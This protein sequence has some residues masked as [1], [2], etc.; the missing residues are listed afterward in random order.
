MKKRFFIVLVLG[1]L[2]I[3]A[4]LA[5][6]LTLADGGQAKAA[7]VVAADAS[8]PQRHAA[9][10]LAA[11]LK[12]VTGAQFDVVHQRDADK[13]NLLVGAPAAKLVDPGFSIDG[14]GSDGIVIRTVGKDLIL[15]G[16]EPRGTLYAVYTFLEEQAGC[17][18]WSSTA[19]T[20]P[21]KPVL[22]VPELQ[23]R[24]VPALEH[25]EVFM[26]DSIDPDWSV[27]NKCVGETHGMGNLPA[28]AQ[29]GGC[30]KY[31]PTAHSF[32]IVLPPDR[33]FKDH[34]E[35]YSLINGKRTAADSTHSE[36]CLTN[37]QMRQE[38]TRR[39]K[40]EVRWASKDY[41]ARGVSVSYASIGE[42]DDAGYPCRCQCDKCR[43]VEIEEGSPAGLLLRFTNSVAAE[44]E[45]EFP[46]IAISMLAYHSWQKPPK[47]TKPRP[48]VI[49]RLVDIT[50]SFSAPISDPRNSRFAEDLV[51]WS[52]LTKRLY[53]WDEIA[54]FNYQ[55]LPHP[56]LRVLAPNIQFFVKH[57]VKGIF[58]EGVNWGS[59]GTKNSEMAQLR[60]W[61]LA[62]LMWNPSLDGQKLIEEFC[63][64]YFGP[65]GD[66]VLAY[67]KVTHDAIES[68]GDWLGLGEPTATPYM[69][70]LTAPTL[71]KGW[72]HL[73]EAERA[74]QADPELL[75][76]VRV[77]QLP[78]LYAFISRWTEMRDDA[79]SRGE[80][81][82]LT[83]SIQEAFD[84]FVK[85]AR[86]N[87]VNI[88]A[89]LPAAFAREQKVIGVVP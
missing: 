16:G 68:S 30:R 4:G 22:S 71:I 36:L 2:G 25:R 54:N 45:E 10:E 64:G 59:G 76:R 46:D 33:Y 12:Q 28:M 70:F 61:V 89:A 73:K 48:N 44:M 52:K 26:P 55:V 40:E 1:V 51:G 77:A 6:G 8:L 78:V 21:K 56:N 57:G 74:V 83:E 86:A 47:L 84:D 32:F 19:S 24:Y 66:G 81:W 7:I 37:D 41:A 63:R 38:F 85:V 20:I 65:G 29:R 53:V 3:A 80:E 5:E 72:K 87:D 17:R 49:V 14:L 9:D 62:K 27:R 82:P 79:I 15:A 67:L 39:M 75:A 69:K 42:S 60:S 43:A 50:C 23:V 31:W 18:W 34:P 35:W 11:F 58:A 13:I 88:D